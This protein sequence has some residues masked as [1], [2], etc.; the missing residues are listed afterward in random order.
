MS[1]DA[2]GLFNIVQKGNGWANQ[3]TRL[4][5]N[6]SG[7]V[8]IGTTT[9]AYPLTINQT[10]NSVNRILSLAND[11]SGSSAQAAVS[12]FEGAT[13]KFKFGI[14]SSGA[15]GYAGGANA[16]QL[17]HF[18]N[19][20]IV[21]GTNSVE[22]MRIAA[23]GNVGIGA[24]NPA[25]ARLHIFSDASGASEYTGGGFPELT[26][27]SGQNTD[28]YFLSPNTGS[29]RL[30]FGSP[31]SNV[32]G[33]IMYFHNA[34]PANGYMYFSAGN[35]S[36]KMRILGNGNIGIGTTAPASKLEVAGTIHS[37][38]GGIKFPDGSVQTTAAS[39]G[40]AG[41]VTS[42]FGR[43]GVVTAAPGDYTWAQIT[44]T[45]SSLA[46]ITTR[47]AG[48]LSSGT[49]PDG[50]FPA[51]LPA[52][53]GANL[54]SLNA[55]NLTSGTV[56]TA[57]LGSGTAN[58]TTFLRGDNTWTAIT[59][60]QWTTSGNNINY[61]TAGNVGIGVGNPSSKLDVNGNINVSGT[62]NITAARHDRSW[63]H[64]GKVPGP[65]RMGTVF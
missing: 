5:I 31:S 54:T 34:T 37:T 32:A 8:G 49:L 52:I 59:S 64:Q 39:G 33:G 27:E 36:E 40:G 20:P 51:T 35:N 19:A 3:G 25:N 11:S 26:L 22:R 38:A 48:D 7:N 62:G 4:T 44:K 46:D 15:T 18:Q 28:L 47:S 45:T 6:R 55:G 60:S 12:F 58:N 42:V 61:A 23:S 57:R 10:G 21:F 30:W 50:R 65:R 1:T 14:N 9:P 53:S 43:D 56:P 13:E 24:A 41:S 17:W 63:Q 29:A 16:F 2:S